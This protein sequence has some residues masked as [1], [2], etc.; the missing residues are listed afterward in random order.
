MLGGISI[1]QRIEQTLM[2]DL[3]SEDGLTKGRRFNNVHINLFV[4]SPPLCAEVK[5]VVKK[6]SSFS[7]CSQYR[8]KAKKQKF[9]NYRRQR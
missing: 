8:N 5:D 3:K 6:L 4:F 7:F 2:R 9:K 1:D